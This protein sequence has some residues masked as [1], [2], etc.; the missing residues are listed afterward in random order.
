MRINRP[1]LPAAILG[2]IITLVCCASVSAQ[3]AQPQNPPPQTTSDPIEQ[4]RLTPEQRQ[5]I[6]AV[7]E[8]TR[9]ERAQINQR[10]REANF[11]FNKAMDDDV[12]D[13]A[14]IEQRLREL[15]A[16]QAASMRI[17]VL[18]EVK[19]R[20]VLT[21]E[22][23]ATLK[24]LQSIA[25]DPNQNTRPNRQGNVLRPNQRNGIAPIFPRRDGVQRNPRP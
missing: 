3:D 18:T 2:I 9:L 14:V 17:R 6:R 24:S 13:E 23:V 19:I 8:S 12:L 5:K 15:A 25:R 20:K 11:A 4:L 10:L 1:P 16:A 7:R 22:Q 21:P